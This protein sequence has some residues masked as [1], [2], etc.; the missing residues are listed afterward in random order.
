MERTTTIGRE[1]EANALLRITDEDIFVETLLAQLG[2]FP[3]YFLRLAE[4]NRHG[5][6][7]P[8]PPTL[9][10]LS[11]A[12]TL[13]WRARGAE[14]VDVR[15]LEDYAAGHV[16]NSLSIAL[17]PAFATWLGW[18]VPDARTRLVI[19]R[20]DDQD[21]EEIL[22]QARKVG[23]DSVPGELGGGLGA[24]AAAGEPIASV[25]LVEPAAASGRAFLDIR[26]DAE[27]AAGHLPGATHVELGALAG[28]DPA[29]L[30]AGVVAM[31]GHGERAAS[32]ASVLE[33]LGRHDVSVLVGGLE[34]VAAAAGGELA[35]S[36]SQ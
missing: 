18:L 6:P 22:W 28:A 10:R 27:H 31:Y 2:S 30:P 21:A 4:V 12:E 24:W 1:L 34:E 14:I 19:G 36:G 25:D 5:P 7:L 13:A 8:A 35:R 20:N 26:Q 33:R 23:Y 29:G 9:D 16:P 32:A 3:P 17:R 15:P 11:V